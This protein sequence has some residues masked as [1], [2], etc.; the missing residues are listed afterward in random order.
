MYMYM[1]EY[2]VGCTLS[3]IKYDTLSID[4]SGLKCENLLYNCI[5]C[6]YC[7]SHKYFRCNI[8]MQLNTD[9]CP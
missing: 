3:N 2:R 7:F 5:V 4:D 6:L 8:F 9:F 1:L